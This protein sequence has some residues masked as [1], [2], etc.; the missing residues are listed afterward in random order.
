MN[1]VSL[2]QMLL[3]LLFHISV[4]KREKRKKKGKKISYHMFLKQAVVV[5]LLEK[6]LLTIKLEV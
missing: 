3:F 4:L 5:K 2:L 1:R 6:L